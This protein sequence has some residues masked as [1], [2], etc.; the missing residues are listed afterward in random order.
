M[1]LAD[2]RNQEEN[3]KLIQV[4]KNT[5]AKCQFRFAIGIEAVFGKKKFNV[6]KCLKLNRLHK[7]G[8]GHLPRDYSQKYV[9]E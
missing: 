4:I 3:E 8:K 7:L 1:K 9:L 5:T 2:V 6:D